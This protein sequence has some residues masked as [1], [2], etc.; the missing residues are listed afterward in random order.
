[1]LDAQRPA[2]GLG[3]IAGLERGD[4]AAR[5]SL[6]LA[7]LVEGG[8]VARAH[9]AAVAPVERQVVG[10]RRRE[11][12]RQARSSAASPPRRGCDLGRERRD[13]A[14]QIADR[15]RR[16]QAVAQAGEV[17][18]AAALE[19]KPR[20]RPGDIR[21]AAQGGAQA[22]R[23]AP[24]SSAR[25]R[26]RG[27][28][29]ESRRGRPKGRRRA[30]R[31]AARRSAETVRSIVATRLP[32][33]SPASVRVSSRLARVAA[34]ID[35][36][37]G[38]R[39]ATRRLERRPLRRTGCARRNASAAP[40]AGRLGAREGA[41]AVER[42]DAEEVPQAPLGGGR[43]EPV[44]GDGRHAARVSRHRFRSSGSSRN[45]SGTTISRGS[46]RAI[47]AA[48]PAASVS[49]SAK[50]PVEMSSAARP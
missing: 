48:S 34:S 30:R 43:I 44:A 4:E 13:A 20:Q 32:A 35:E 28:A 24:R 14:E 12:L 45:W 18:R 23:A 29:R 5:I 9:E 49:D 7:R 27:L 36:D 3:G 31:G 25:K 50:R 46:K 38:R 11:R 41:E 10:E 40:A 39:L 6:Q 19:R 26:D 37:A 16:N 17:A 21:H 15:C 33:R 42:R 22:P 47:S 2:A 8:L 1:M